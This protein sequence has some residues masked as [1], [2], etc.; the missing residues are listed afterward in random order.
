[1]TQ[2][3]KD[4][5]QATKDET[6]PFLLE[7][8]HGTNKKSPNVMV[9]DKTTLQ[10]KSESALKQNC[11]RTQHAPEVFN[12]AK[13][14]SNSQFSICLVVITPSTEFENFSP[15]NFSPERRNLDPSELGDKWV[16]VNCSFGSIWNKLQHVD[17]ENLSLMHQKT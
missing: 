12:L 4:M 3:W 11:P 9:Q 8:M 6:Q 14:P 5:P 16:A 15:E 17:K 1:M 10:N 13:K 7:D 2:N